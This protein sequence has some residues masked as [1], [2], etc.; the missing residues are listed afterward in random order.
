M[1]QSDAWYGTP[2]AKRIADNLL[3]Y[4][5][6]AGGWPK[7]IDMAAPLTSRVQ[8]SLCQYNDE[9]EC[10]IDNTATYT[11][12]RFL[13][14]VYAAQGGGQYRKSFLRGFDYMLKA[15]YDNGGWPQF[16]PLRKGYYTHIT[17]ND[18]AIIGV[19]TLLTDAVEK[20]T[21][22]RFV[23]A[24]R[25]K[26]AAVAIR[27]GIDC[28]LKCQVRVNGV[29]TVWC[30]QNDEHSF[31]PAKA[32]AYE[33]PSLSGKESVSIIRYLMNIKHPSP[34]IAASVRAAVAWFER[35]KVKGVRVD[36]VPNSLSPTGMNK[37]VVDDSQAPPLWA[38][39]YDIETNKPIYV[40]RDGIV[41]SALADISYERRNHYGWLEP[42]AKE[43]LSKDYPVWEKRMLRK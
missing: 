41:R 1:D 39:F 4:Q 2:E 28:I 12:M 6:K 42:W 14:A 26:K 18:D 15:Q 32:R 7:N 43:L 33:L 9:T 19:M 3:L 11:Q 24:P 30:A 16:Y 35:S 37:V 17:F 29:L 10:T 40:S 13:A 5:G 25:L 36:V 8:D 31:A 21:P 34:E 27:K 38:R 20:K 23:D 22:F